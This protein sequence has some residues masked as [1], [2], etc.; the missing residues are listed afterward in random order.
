MAISNRRSARVHLGVHARTRAR[1]CA[2][3]AG[4]LGDLSDICRTVTLGCARIEVRKT[5][6]K[7][8]EDGHA[9]V[10]RT[11]VRTYVRA[12]ARVVPVV[13]IWAA[14]ACP[15]PSA[16][17]A[18]VT[19]GAPPELPDARPAMP[20]CVD[21]FSA[22]IQSTLASRQPGSEDNADEPATP[23]ASAA[24][25]DT[26][27]STPTGD[28]NGKRARA[29][30]HEDES[31]KKRRG[32]YPSRRKPPTPVASWEIDGHTSKTSD[33]R[34]LFVKAC[35]A[36]VNGE[37]VKSGKAV[38]EIPT[39]IPLWPQYHLQVRGS[40]TGGSETTWLHANLNEQW[41]NDIADSLTNSKVRD[42]VAHTM[43]LLSLRLN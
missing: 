29:D 36:V 33:L 17:L 4:A 24:A 37:K 2:D 41:L 40:D 21:L 28:S 22:A 3:L 6:R 43:A 7:H 1:R 25:S 35:P 42:V 34:C 13:P 11:Y 10:V 14:V 31:A 15:R 39:A 32:L 30:A 19:R 27:P 23:S 38:E 20:G 12:H 9:T 16:I 18:R 5:K 8:A 26:S